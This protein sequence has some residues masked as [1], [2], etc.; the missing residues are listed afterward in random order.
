[1]KRYMI[2]HWE[3]RRGEG[4]R[5][6][7]HLDGLI[8]GK[9]AASLSLIQDSRDCVP[10]A[11]LGLCFPEIN[12]ENALEL[13][14][15]TWKNYMCTKSVNIL[16]IKYLYGWFIW[17]VIICFCLF[18]VI[19]FPKYKTLQMTNQQKINRNLWKG[20]SILSI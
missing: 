9:Q 16:I 8:W 2:Q 13:C 12:L 6:T 10:T 17:I 15:H 1:M 18:S 7:I 19:S 14:S 4:R 3:M 5:R 11:F 20:I